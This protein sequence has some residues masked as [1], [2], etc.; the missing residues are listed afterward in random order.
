MKSFDDVFDTI[1]RGTLMPMGRIGRMAFDVP[2]DVIEYDNE[3]IVHLSVS[4]FKKENISVNY[5]D[6]ILSISGTSE[7]NN[8]DEEKGKYIIKE[9]SSR[10][11]ERSFCVRGVDEEKISAKMEDGV[12]TIVLPKAEEESPSSINI[13]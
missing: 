3:Y 8:E 6:G 10:K 7:V 13:D 1:Q 4:G 5:K 11:F 2:A 9:R 12:L